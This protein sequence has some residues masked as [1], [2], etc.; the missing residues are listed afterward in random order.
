MT[1]TGTAENPGTLRIPGLAGMKSAGERAA[2]IDSL[3]EGYG[4]IFSVNVYLHWVWMLVIAA[5]IFGIIL[6]L[7]KR[8]DIL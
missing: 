6:F 4:D 2:T 7:Q 3:A 1:G 5:V 8:R